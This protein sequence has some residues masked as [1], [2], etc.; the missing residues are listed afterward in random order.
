MSRLS[1]RQ[2]KFA[3]A[4]IVSGNIQQSALSAGYSSS[5]SESR[6]YLLLDYPAVKDYIAS[7]MAELEKP[8]IASQDEVLQVL[9]K[10]LRQELLE[11]LVV[12]S[13]VTGQFVVSEKKPAISD[14]LRASAELLKRYPVKF[15]DR[16]SEEKIAELFTK[17]LGSVDE[18]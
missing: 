17:I 11:E 14:V 12:L 4:Y 15:D 8:A 5:F 3:D 18:Y 1:V 9:T 13:P 7:R 6:A 2:R 16:K 10:V